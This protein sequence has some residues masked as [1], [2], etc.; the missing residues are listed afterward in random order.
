M[1]ADC[2]VCLI[3]EP[4]RSENQDLDQFWPCAHLHYKL[5]LEVV[6]IKIATFRLQTTGA[7]VSFL[8]FSLPS[9][10]FQ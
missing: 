7:S 1:L 2:T 3:L 6:C 9:A 10:C 4:F 8:V 5:V